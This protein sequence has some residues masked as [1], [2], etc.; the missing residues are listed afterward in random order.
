[1]I[2]IWNNWL[3]SKQ[4]YFH[5]F[6]WMNEQ[7]KCKMHVYLRFPCDC[8]TRNSLVKRRESFTILYTQL[9]NWMCKRRFIS[10]LKAFK[11]LN[12]TVFHF[13]R[14]VRSHFCENSNFFK[15][16][17][18]VRNHWSKSTKYGYFCLKILKKQGVGY[19]CYFL[20]IFIFFFKKMSNE[21]RNLIWNKHGN[22]WAFGHFFIQPFFYYIQDA[23]K[24]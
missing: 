6:W 20:N 1:M 23:I 15:N 21:S 13:P 17:K 5:Q 19:F 12:V 10:L 16:E 2:L 18:C 24:K 8:W 9:W 7:F 4:K 3:E 14:L 22:N 11:V